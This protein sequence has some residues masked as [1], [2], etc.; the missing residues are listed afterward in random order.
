MDGC[1]IYRTLCV[2]SVLVFSFIFKFCHR[3][4]HGTKHFI[5]VLCE[6]PFTLSFHFCLNFRFISVLLRF[7][8]VTVG[9]TN[10]RHISLHHTCASSY[11]Q[12]QKTTIFHTSAE[13]FFI[14][15]LNTLSKKFYDTFIGLSAV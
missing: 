14:K 8:D 13:I 10:M 11:V 4:R 1:K 12:R 9:H 6:F 5:S 2:I 15:A 3:K 7:H